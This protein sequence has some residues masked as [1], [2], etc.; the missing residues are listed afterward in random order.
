MPLGAISRLITQF[1]ALLDRRE[2]AIL[3]GE[4]GG[5]LLGGRRCS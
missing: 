4:A 2:G 3:D 5:L 1:C